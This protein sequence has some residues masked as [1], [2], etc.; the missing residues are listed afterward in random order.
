LRE[1]L[2]DEAYESFARA[3]ENMTNA[4]MATYAFDQIDRARVELL[5][6]TEPT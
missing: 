6:R 5:G 2:G 3:G 4:A 1:V